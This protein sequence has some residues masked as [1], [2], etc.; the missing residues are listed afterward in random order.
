MTDGAIF[1]II[2]RQEMIAAMSNVIDADPCAPVRSYDQ[3]VANV[4]VQYPSDYI[5]T[6][7]CA[8]SAE[9]KT[10]FRV[11][12]STHNPRCCNRR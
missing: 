2:A 1:S 5:P 10:C 6:F 3:V 12:S 9:T 4:G 8:V 7:H 11:S